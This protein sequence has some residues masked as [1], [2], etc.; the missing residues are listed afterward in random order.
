MDNENVTTL[1]NAAAEKRGSDFETA[2]AAEVHARI[3]QNVDHER[4]E[5]AQNFFAP[6]VEAEA[7]K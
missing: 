1:V 2:F 7:A 4:T 6:K 3:A 5:I